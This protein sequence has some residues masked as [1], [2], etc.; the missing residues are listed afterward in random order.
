MAVLEV[1]FSR[2]G[3]YVVQSA[4]THVCA[5]MSVHVGCSWLD[6]GVGWGG[7]GVDFVAF[8]SEKLVLT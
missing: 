3:T 7:G 8:K 2:G 6:Y 4:V 1:I 5:Y